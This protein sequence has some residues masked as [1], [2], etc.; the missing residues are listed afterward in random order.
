MIAKLLIDLKL[1]REI[2]VVEWSALFALWA[3]ACTLTLVFK[4]YYNQDIGVSVFVVE[5]LEGVG[6]VE[7]LET[8]SI[9]FYLLRAIGDSFIFR[10]DYLLL[11]YCF[12]ITAQMFII[13][14][15]AK[16][17]NLYYAI[18]IVLIIFFTVILNQMRFGIA[19]SVMLLSL[20]R[21]I[22]QPRDIAIQIGLGTIILL[23]H[24]FV[25]LFYILY[26]ICRKYNYLIYILGAIA[27]IGYSSLNFLLADS[28]YIFYL[29]EDVLRGSFS[30]LLF[31]GIYAISFINLDYF[32]RLF[33][34]FLVVIA[35]A[36]Y[37]LAS[38]SSRLSELSIIFLLVV[39][40]KKETN[41]LTKLLLLGCSLSFFLYRA[42][43]WFVLD[44][45]PLA[46]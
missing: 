7:A 2:K 8:N 45:V 19:I 11:M 14:S 27:V 4:G 22:K 5:N 17:S 3:L 6:F 18:L 23:F 21:T 29:E 30:F 15:L 40:S 38:V 20:N 42:Y 34:L 26:L 37:N 36:S 41:A 1:Y 43:N 10:G 35:A 13:S 39:L 44:M 46:P 25:G 28:R 31:L 16:Y 12:Y 33:F 24:I 9:I 32:H